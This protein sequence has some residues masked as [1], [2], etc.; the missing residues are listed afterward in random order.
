MS[1]WREKSKGGLN[2][3]SLIPWRKISTADASRTNELMSSCQ[4][5]MCFRHWSLKIT[6]L[7]LN[8]QESN[9][10]KL[11]GWAESIKLTRVLLTRAINSSL[12]YCR[13]KYMLGHITVYNAEDW[14][15]FKWE[16]WEVWKT[17]GPVTET[18]K[19]NGRKTWRKFV[20][21]SLQT[22]CERASRKRWRKYDA[23]QAKSRTSRSASSQ[24][25]VNSVRTLFITG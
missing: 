5:R 20:I 16:T 6:P 19:Y 1:V 8:N 7:P 3:V 12:Q 24:T 11:R 13:Y 22:T 23:K 25:W 2:I 14:I 9:T 18:K 21:M 17:T 4:S 10:Q 15:D